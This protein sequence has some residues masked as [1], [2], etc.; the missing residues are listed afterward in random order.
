MLRRVLG[1]LS[2][3]LLVGEASSAEEALARVGDARPDVVVMDRQ[4]AGIGG[5]EATARLLRD[6]PDVRIVGYTSSADDDTH[7]AFAE[8]G[9]A[10][11][12]HKRDALALRA[13]LRALA[14]GEA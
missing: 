4:M 8:A 11:V 14:A 9:A 1:E 10:A 7:R 5:V 6:H 12:F 2:A 3:V 13:W